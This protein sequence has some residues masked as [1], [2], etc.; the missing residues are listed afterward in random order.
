[1]TRKLALIAGIVIAVGALWVGMRRIIPSTVDYRGEKIKLTK[2]YLDYDEYK[3]DPDNIDPSETARVQ[4]LVTEAPIARSFPDR[5]TA[6]SA[7]F[8]IKF[9]GYAAGGF[10]DGI[11]RNEGSLN[12]LVVEIPRSDSSRYFIFRL[13]NGRYTLVDDFTASGSLDIH[14]VR[15]ENGSLVY[16]TASGQ[17]RLTRPPLQSAAYH[18]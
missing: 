5:M 15:D 4:R 2:F 16:C 7:V 14:N 12:G 1:M 9:P 6:V 11:Q 13:V 10:G 18:P 17:P 3:N 8:K